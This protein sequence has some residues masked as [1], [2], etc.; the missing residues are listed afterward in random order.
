MTTRGQLR[1]AALA[2]PEA[3]EG[4][5]FGMPAFSVRGKEFASLTGDGW[6]QLR[7]SDAE[8]A[9]VLAEH[10]IGERL[11][12]MGEPIGVRMPLAEINGMVLNA[13]VRAAWKH[14]AP[15]R[16]AAAYADAVQGD[17]SRGDLPAAIGRP[18]MRAL[19]GAGMT[20]L[21]QVADRSETELLALHGVGPRA[22]G[23]LIEALEREGRSLRREA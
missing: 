22:V 6:V 9:S 21:D 20:G 7:L 3:E 15:K 12:R 2:L 13:L 18:A 16:L 11:V 10:P 17:P 5:H 8:A 19:H 4:T 14:R 23:V 1:K